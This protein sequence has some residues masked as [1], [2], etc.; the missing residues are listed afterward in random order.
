MRHRSLLVL[1]LAT[2]LAACAQTRAIT[3]PS[4]AAVDEQLRPGQPIYVLLHDGREHR[5][6]FQRVEDGRLWLRAPHAPDLALPLSEVRY[7][8]FAGRSATPAVHGAMGVTAVLL[9]IIA[10]LGALAVAAM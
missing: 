6:T 10:A 7:L 2:L 9:G 5:G 3:Q 4:A 1:L 8:E